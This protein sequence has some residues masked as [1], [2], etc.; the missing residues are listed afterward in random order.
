MIGTSLPKAVAQ[1]QRS[2]KNQMFLL[3]WVLKPTFQWRSGCASREVQVPH[4]VYPERSQKQILRSAQ[5]D[6]R[7]ARDDAP[8]TYG[9]KEGIFF[10]LFSARLKSCP[11][12]LF[13]ESCKG[14]TPGTC[15]GRLLTRA[16]P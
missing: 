7:R 1:R 2:D 15:L 13:S 9:S 16:A 5:N 4:G 12:G 10:R 6:K 3:V 14:L 11:D 8:V